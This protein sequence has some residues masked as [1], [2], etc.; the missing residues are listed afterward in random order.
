MG[1]GSPCHT[2]A[3]QVAGE[4]APV[5]FGNAC[6]ASQQ[7]ASITPEPIKQAPMPPT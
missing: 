1:D 5:L 7:L 3:G 4:D 2:R 6:V